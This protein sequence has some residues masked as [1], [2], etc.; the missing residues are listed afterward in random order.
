M[1][2]YGKEIILN[3]KSIYTSTSDHLYI[4]VDE[5]DSRTNFRLDPYIKVYQTS[6][7]EK[8]ARISLN[9][10]YYVIHYKGADFLPIKEENKN[11]LNMIIK[12]A[13]NKYKYPNCK[14][15]Y[16]AIIYTIAEMQNC[17]IEDVVVPAIDKIDF[18]NVCLSPE[19][20]SKYGYLLSRRK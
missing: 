7:R 6:N 5:D 4:S 10:M 16:D 14:T 12:S 17:R 19:D 9:T 13:P 2:F 11:K 20:Y 18:N 1:S 3:E 8:V 15:V